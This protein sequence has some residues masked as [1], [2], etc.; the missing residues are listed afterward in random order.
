M[1][2]AGYVTSVGT[3]VIFTVPFAVPIIGAP[4]VTVASG[5]GFILRQNNKYTHGSDSS[6]YTTPV[7][8]TATIAQ[9]CGVYIEAKFSDAQAALNVINNAPIGIYWNG[10]ITFS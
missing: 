10:T 5:N 4:T 8:Y 3:T 2:T 1:R 7:S 6:T 9:W